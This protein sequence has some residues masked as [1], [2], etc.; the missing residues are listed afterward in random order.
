MS[1]DTPAG[2]YKLGDWFIP[3]YQRGLTCTS[4]ENSDDPPRHPC[5]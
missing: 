5:P 3:G 2:Q 1:E 4:G